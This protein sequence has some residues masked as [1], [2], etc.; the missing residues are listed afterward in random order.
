MSRPL[1]SRPSPSPSTAGMTKRCW[2]VTRASQAAGKPVR[3]DSQMPTRPSTP[4]TAITGP[5]NSTARGSV[6]RPPPIKAMYRLTTPRNASMHSHTRVELAKADGPRSRR[7][8][9]VVRASGAG[10]EMD[11]DMTAF[12][13]LWSDAGRGGRRGDLGSRVRRGRAA[14]SRPGRDDDDEADQCLGDQRQ[15]RHVVVVWIESRQKSRAEP[16]KTG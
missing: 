9:T 5:L 6:S 12:T 10:W 16:A 4:T 2:P 8:R 7:A 1:S 3:C 14:E 13:F 15:Q 11:V